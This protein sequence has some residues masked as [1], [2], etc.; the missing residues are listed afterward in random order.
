MSRFVI[1]IDAGGTSVRLALSEGETRPGIPL[2]E[3]QGAADPEGGPAPVEALLHEVLDQVGG[4]SAK[5]IGAVCAGITKVSRAGVQAQWEAEL[6]RLLPAAA[7]QVVPDFVVAFHGAIPDG[8]GVA[9]VAGTGSVVYGENGRG[10]AVRV[11]G[12]GWEFGDE[13]S[14]AWLT[15]EA[16]R[17]TLRALDGL[18]EESELTKAV[19]VSLEAQEAGLLGQNAR[20]RG[21][22][23]GRGFLVPLVLEK[24]RG[25][26][27]EAAN[28]F[29]GAA[30]WLAA[31]VRAVQQRL[32]LAPDEAFTVATIGG[33]W[34]AGELL[35]APFTQVLHRW[36]PAAQIT[37]PAEAPVQGAV[38]MAQR[39]QDA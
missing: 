25:G 16:I 29:V 18:E 37:P 28:L 33:L 36:A 20:V 11:G 13:G 4:L 38:R 6:A 35:T 19:C 26:D 3:R 14:G 17:R 30:G 9:V 39:L 1:G 32:P 15:T 10:G 23:E 22:D 21:L 8:I 2:V 34:S 12:R 5:A 24:A 27:K 7:V 31:Q